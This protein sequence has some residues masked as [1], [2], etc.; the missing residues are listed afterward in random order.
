[1]SVKSEDFQALGFFDSLNARFQARQVAGARH[2][3][4]L[5]AVA[6]K[7]LFGWPISVLLTVMVR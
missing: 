6:C 1:M 2:E 4:R 3:R 7:P 5:F